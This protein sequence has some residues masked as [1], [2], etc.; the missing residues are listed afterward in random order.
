MVAMLEV[1]TTE[2]QRSVV[3]FYGQKDSMQRILIKK[4]LLF[5]VRSSDFQLFCPLKKPPWWQAFRL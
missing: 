4:I 2:E 3:R 1:C 5:T